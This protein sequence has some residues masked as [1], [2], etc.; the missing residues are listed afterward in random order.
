MKAA[1]PSRAPLPRPVGLIAGKDHCPWF[2]DDLYF[3]GNKAVSNIL[4]KLEV[5]LY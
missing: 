4:V 5:V 1:T 3:Q 2:R